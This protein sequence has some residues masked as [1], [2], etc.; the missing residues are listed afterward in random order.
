MSAA[1]AKHHLEQLLKTVEEGQTVTISRYRKPIAQIVPLCATPQIAPRFG[2]GRGM[3]RIMD[4][5]WDKAIETEEEL[6]AFLQG[7]I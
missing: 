1:Y 5:R 7:K 6:A 4:P 2:T 3:V